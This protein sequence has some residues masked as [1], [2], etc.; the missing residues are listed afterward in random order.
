VKTTP[1]LELGS[2][3]AL[4]S[5]GGGQAWADFDVSL[6]GKRFLAIT[7]VRFADEQPLSVVL[8]WTADAKR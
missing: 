1:A 7:R 3:T 6:D 5:I 4:L 2:P 8:N